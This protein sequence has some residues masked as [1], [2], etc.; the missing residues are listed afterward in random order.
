M[1]TLTFS[2]FRLLHKVGF[3]KSNG[4]QRPHQLSQVT[5]ELRGCGREGLSGRNAS[6]HLRC[7]VDH[8]AS[9]GPVVTKSGEDERQIKE[10]QSFRC[11]ALGKSSASFTFISE[12]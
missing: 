10:A 1:S 7:G 12:A 2:L 9:Q 6:T 11:T 5:L 3:K 8:T 4:K